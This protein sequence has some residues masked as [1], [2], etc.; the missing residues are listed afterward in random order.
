MKK[1]GENIWKPNHKANI[2]L[3]GIP[4]RTNRNRKL[5]RHNRKTK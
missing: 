5:E 2:L 3:I 1:K 4:Q